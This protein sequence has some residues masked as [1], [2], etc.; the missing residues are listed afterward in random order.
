MGGGGPAGRVKAPVC[1][2]DRRP[3][4][5]RVAARK[6]RTGAPAG[7]A[8]CRAPSPGSE[9]A[10]ATAGFARKTAARA[11]EAAGLGGERGV[12]RADA[13]PALSA[14]P[15]S[16]T[17]RCPSGRRLGAPGIRAGL[18]DFPYPH[19]GRAQEPGDCLPGPPEPTPSETR[20]W[21][22][23]IRSNRQPARV[24]WFSGRGQGGSLNPFPPFYLCLRSQVDSL[25]FKICLSSVQWLSRV[26]LFATP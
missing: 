3:G 4:Y 14:A 5:L 12:A 24:T 18:R 21:R 25:I 20:P 2:A 13:A 17:R 26:R 16:L 11:A 10:G 15:A 22:D 7:A 6:A 1:C 9:P 19:G 8:R 23:Q